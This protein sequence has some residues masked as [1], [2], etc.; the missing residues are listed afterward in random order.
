MEKQLGWRLAPHRAIRFQF[1]NMKTIE[2]H[3]QKLKCHCF[4]DITSSANSTHF[5]KCTTKKTDQNN[6]LLPFRF[7]FGFFPLCAALWQSRKKLYCSIWGLHFRRRHSPE[8]WPEL[9]HDFLTFS[10]SIEIFVCAYL[11]IRS[12]RSVS[13]QRNELNQQMKVTQINFVPVFREM[14]N[15]C[16]CC[17]CYGCYSGPFLFLVTFV[18][19]SLH[20]I[21]LCAFYSIEMS[22]VAVES[23]NNTGTF[24]LKPF[25][26][27]SCQFA[28]VAISPR[29]RQIF[30]CLFWIFLA[31]NFAHAMNTRIIKC[32][33]TSP[34]GNRPV[35]KENKARTL[36]GR[37]F[38]KRSESYRIRAAQ[39]IPVSIPSLFTGRCWDRNNGL[40]SDYLLNHCLRFAARSRSTNLIHPHKHRH[41][42]VNKCENESP[43]ITAR[44]S[45]MYDV[46]YIAH[47]NFAL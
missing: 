28:A 29:V 34:T 6:F 20:A 41:A 13:S 27:D 10:H 30:V 21:A 5:R 12:S 24:L 7:W 3:G 33:F 17:C 40:T 46:L 19:T 31:L 16:C 26:S 37:A 25:R 42:A 35:L 44:S 1:E 23:T 18:H 14:F 11:C 38:S 32:A 39:S 43:W 36:M 8:N 2:R 4:S 22:N 9:L 47:T 45:M 15:V